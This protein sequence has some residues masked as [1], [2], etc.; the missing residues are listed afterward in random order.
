[1]VREL[2]PCFPSLVPLYMHILHSLQ[3]HYIWLNWLWAEQ[4][5]LTVTLCFN[6]IFTESQHPHAQDYVLLIIA[7][8]P[9][10]EFRANLLGFAAPTSQWRL[11]LNTTA[12]WLHWC[13]AV[14]SMEISSLANTTTLTD[15]LICVYQMDK[16]IKNNQLLSLY[17]NAKTLRF[18]IFM[19]FYASVP[20][21][22]RTERLLFSDCLVS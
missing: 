18:I 12:L 10:S 15:V 17:Q 7:A 9:V 8:R 16:W 6:F 22:A 4:H 20:V 3:N 5:S 1:M 19:G 2:G 11:L 14:L 21:A 13:S